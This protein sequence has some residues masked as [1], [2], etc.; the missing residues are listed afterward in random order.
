MRRV[1]ALGLALFAVA[2]LGSALASSAFGAK[3]P[4]TILFLATETYPVKIES[5]PVEPNT[6]PWKFENAAG[7]FK[8]EGFLLEAEL[9][10]AGNGNVAEKLGTFDLLFLK[11]KNGT[12]EVCTSTG[13]KNAGE[14]LVDGFL[15]LVHD[16]NATSGLGILFEW[17]E[18]TSEC[19]PSKSA[20]HIKGNQVGLLRPVGT[21]EV[22]TGEV[23]V[24]CS[25]TTIGEPLETEWWDEEEVKHGGKLEANFGSGFKR[26]CLDVGNENEWI[27][28]DMNKMI[29]M[30]F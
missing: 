8:G 28:Y 16:I 20:S 6:I 13:E 30:M 24:H 5:L 19:L 15:K 22:T 18:V 3:L 10:K 29:E 25:A 17:L 2:L 14:V 1:I 27:R 12:G 7:E 21:G 26:A 4:M 9:T 11:V 23:F